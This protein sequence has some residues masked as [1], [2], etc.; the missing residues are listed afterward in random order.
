[1]R[2]L[3]VLLLAGCNQPPPQQ[4]T[5]PDPPPATFTHYAL[6]PVNAAYAWRLNVETGDVHLCMVGPPITAPTA[7]CLELTVK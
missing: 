6:Y 7:E 2:Y 4:I 3:I 5:F 1:M